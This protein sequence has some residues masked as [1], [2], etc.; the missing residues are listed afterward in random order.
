MYKNVTLLIAITLLCIGTANAETTIVEPLSDFN[1]IADFKE[2]IVAGSEYSALFEFNARY[3]TIVV[4]NFTVEHPEINEG[5][6][7]GLILFNETVFP[8]E[9]APGV[10]STGEIDIKKG[11]YLVGVQ[12]KSNV[13]IVPGKYNFTLDI[14]SEDILIEP[15]NDG[16]RGGGF[17]LIMPTPNATVKPSDVTIPNVIATS[18]PVTFTVGGQE[19]PQDP[20]GNIWPWNLYFLITLVILMAR[21]WII[22][23]LL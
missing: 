14:L 4:I 13:A 16:R 17:G 7:C 5:E 22:E 6:W 2:N 19:P 3:D 1:P 23:K 20:L 11:Y 18:T 21:G 9:V 8:G 15:S 10:F 12:Y